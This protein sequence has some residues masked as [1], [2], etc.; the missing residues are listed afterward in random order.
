M[1]VA[2]APNLT[3]SF[4]ADKRRLTYDVDTD[5]T[6]GFARELLVSVGLRVE[7]VLFT[8][9]V[10]CLP[11]RKKGKHPVS[12]RQ[13]EL[14]RPWLAKLIEVADP[15]VVITFGAR[16]LDALGRLEEHG[17]T[18]RTGVGKLH[19]WRGRQI[20]PLYH[21]GLLGWVTRN[22]ARQFQDSAVLKHLLAEPYL[23]AAFSFRR[24]RQLPETMTGRPSTCSGV[25]R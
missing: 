23:H 6:G 24:E 12:A 3:D 19:P 21:P 25:R 16:A 9:A 5:P 22:A 7:D 1:V 14:C 13:M 8:N 17:L 11:A 2:E 15:L 10:L 18:L 20:L 4:D